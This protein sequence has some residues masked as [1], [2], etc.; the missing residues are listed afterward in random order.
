MIFVGLHCNE[1]GMYDDWRFESKA[2]MHGNGVWFL[3][4]AS[5]VELVL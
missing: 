1:N 3:A 4:L 2:Q 5:K